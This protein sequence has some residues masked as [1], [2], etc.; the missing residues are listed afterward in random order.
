V[1]YSHD[2]FEHEESVRALADRLRKHGLD[3]RI[4]Q[5]SP[6]PSEGWPT[7]MDAQIRTA[8]FVL[9]I[10]TETYLRRVE[11]REVPGKGRGVLWEA[12]LIYNLLYEDT[13]A[14]R[15]IPVLLTG[16]K[17][18]WV[19][20]PLRGLTYYEVDAESG[21][22]NLYRRLTDQEGHEPQEIGP[23]VP[24][25][26]RLPISYPASPAASP[27][28][29]P[30]AFEQR[31]RRAAIQR[32]RHGIESVLEQ[33]LY[34]V[35]RLDLGLTTRTELVGWNALIQEPDHT[36]RPIPA[37]VPISGV[38]ATHDSLLILGAPGTGKTTLLAELARDLLLDAESDESKPLA[39]LF[40][41]S[42]W[43]VRRQRLTDWMVSELNT[44]IDVPE[45][46]GQQWLDTEQ[47]LPL[48]DGLDE[49]DEA[50]REECVRAI[51]E[52]RHEHGLMPIAV[53]SRI[54]DYEALGTRLRLRYAVEIGLLLRTQ[55]ED[56]MK[57][58]DEPMRD[59]HTTLAEDPL[60][61]EVLQTPLMLWLASRA[62]RY[63]EGESVVSFGTA[64]QRRKQLFERFVRRMFL[65]R[66]RQMK[67][68][69]R[70]LERR[71]AWLA[72]NLGTKGQE[73]FYAENLSNDWMETDLQRR[74]ASVGLVVL[75]TLSAGC[76][77][78]LMDWVNHWVVGGQ[79]GG[80]GGG[81]VGGL[82]GLAVA[83][84]MVA[85]DE[86]RPVRRVTLRLFDI[87][88]RRAE[89]RYAYGDMLF[90][91]LLGFP[92]ALLLI[93]VVNAMVMPFLVKFLGFP[94]RSVLHVG[95]IA[96][97][98]ALICF[99]LLACVG[100]GVIQLRILDPVPETHSSFNQ[101]TR[102]SIKASLL[103]FLSGWL[104]AGGS[105][106][107]FFGVRAG[108]LTGVLIA[109]PGGLLVGGLFSLRHLLVRFILS[110][111]GL[112]P[113]RY[114]LFLKEATQLHFLRREGGY[115]FVHR[116]LREYFASLHT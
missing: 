75:A 86:I 4:D 21:Y 43:A 25:P 100:A 111:S 16:G 37:G 96:L 40:R 113:I 11:R 70:Q 44:H 1:S 76:A 33:P 29:R 15:F 52:F 53:S 61:W 78:W 10:C 80:L 48:L 82:I 72:R 34:K 88:S 114:S 84:S 60:L 42:S 73:T 5:Y 9:L 39:V 107:S 6:A 97:I 20:L 56:Y 59:L 85:A 79:G 41:L 28:P 12:R 81:M 112:A 57:R 108:T 36:P 102:R 98:E 17:Q 32:I 93:E 66:G 27:P 55:V 63:E 64:E 94:P 110:V 71:L 77:G 69:Q 87:W 22:E 35:A 83:N 49:V 109:I 14:Q 51:N 47:I 95:E 101:G 99:A 54:A 58:V 7:W 104:I 67:F 91:A 105:A 31:C 115:V 50:H 8:D 3:A 68:R 24:L 18:D 106:Y 45:N 103:V 62:Y 89:F 30:T 116:L 2:S 65:E 26:P 92:A 74:L 13:Q 90:G 23:V 19:P 38:F 46:L